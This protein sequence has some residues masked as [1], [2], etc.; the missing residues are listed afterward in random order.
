[1]KDEGRWKLHLI[2]SGSWKSINVKIWNPRST[3]F[4]SSEQTISKQRT[5]KLDS[6]WASVKADP[7]F[8]AEL[9]KQNNWKFK[10]FHIKTMN[11]S[12]VI[13]IFL[14]RE[15]FTKYRR[16]ALSKFDPKFWL[17]TKL[18]ICMLWKLFFYNN[19][20]YFHAKEVDT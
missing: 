18:K 15:T 1:M 6:G 8:T 13:V 2:S 19:F 5:V 11:H 10:Y 7:T 20:Y 3:I 17:M 9:Q 12:K 14:H 16:Q 4:L